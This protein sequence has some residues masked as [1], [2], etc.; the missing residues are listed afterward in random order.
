MVTCYQIPHVNDISPEIVGI[1]LHCAF[2]IAELIN[3]GKGLQKK[4]KSQYVTLDSDLSSCMGTFRLSTAE[5]EE[6]EEKDT[7]P[8]SKIWLLVGSRLHDVNVAR[9]PT[10]SYYNYG[11]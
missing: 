5:A 1:L 10:K 3:Q 2:I 4:K 9:F 11:H 8:S 7:H 6:E